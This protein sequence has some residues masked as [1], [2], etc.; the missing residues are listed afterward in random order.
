MRDFAVYDGLLGCDRLVNMASRITAFS[1][2]W[3]FSQ[4][5]VLVILEAVFLL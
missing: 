4:A 3:I 5:G 2:K 1:D